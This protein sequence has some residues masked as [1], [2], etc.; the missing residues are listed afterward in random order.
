MLW[1]VPKQDSQTRV[2][3]QLPAQG[4]EGPIRC[5][6]PGKVIEDGPPQSTFKRAIHGSAARA[7]P[8]GRA[9]ASYLDCVRADSTCQAPRGFKARGAPRGPAPR[10]SAHGQ[11]AAAPHPTRAT[12][13]P[14]GGGS[15][16]TGCSEWGRGY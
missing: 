16:F 6:D 7:P 2:G 10:V 8:L 11:S 9:D 1:L 14:D 13:T 3:R 5:R 15:G 12:P 4:G